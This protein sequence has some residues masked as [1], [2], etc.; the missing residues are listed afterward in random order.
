ME[1]IEGRVDAAEQVAA[2]VQS[3][4]DDA[5][6]LTAPGAALQGVNDAGTDAVRARP[7]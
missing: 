1:R 3:L 5:H 4:A 7:R 2:T 6:A